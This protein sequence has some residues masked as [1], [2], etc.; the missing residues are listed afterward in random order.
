LQPCSKKN[1]LYLSAIGLI[2][3]IVMQLIS[4][5]FKIPTCTLCLYQQYMY[6][7]FCIWNLL[8]F[9]YPCKVLFNLGNNCILIFNLGLAIFQS[10]GQYGFLLLKCKPVSIEQVINNGADCSEKSIELL[11]LSFSEW[12]CILVFALLIFINIK[13]YRRTRG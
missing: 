3:F 8:L 7:F 2:I 6:L 13:A 1:G 11:G 5:N 12:N 4:L 9:F 10:L